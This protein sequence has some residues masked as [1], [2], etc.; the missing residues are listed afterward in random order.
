MKKSV[1][2]ALLCIIIALVIAASIFVFVKPSKKDPS[3]APETEQQQQEQ[4]KEK[5]KE[6][7]KE[8]EEE[9]KEEEQEPE[10]E[11]EPE[12]KPEPEPEPV[13]KPDTPVSNE[14]PTVDI[15]VYTM[16]TSYK[17]FALTKGMSANEAYNKLNSFLQSKYSI[18]INKQ[19][20]VESTY[21]PTDLVTLSGFSYPLESTAANALK[22]LVTDARANGITDLVLYSGYRRY[23]SQKTKY[24][25]RIQRY[26]NE[27][28]SQENA[29]KKAGEYIAPPG[30]S[31]HHTGLAA[32]VC[33]SAIVNKYGYLSDSF[34]TTKEYRWLRDN[35]ANYGFIVRYM[36]GKESITGFLYEPWHL[37]YLGVEH[38]KACTG[39]GL[40]YEEY[41]ALLTKLCNEAKADAGV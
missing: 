12:P 3:P 16:P 13:T 5:E 19:H 30:S 40:T 25:T 17:D 27:G 10:P 14:Q 15:T 35:C 4:K 21:A 7:E 2:N 20:K 23:S 34:D 39:L 37:R 24:E 31:E 8:E 28:Y 26:L 38:A 6:K 11:P 18:L 32:D 22:S 41:H 33:S 1:F 29:E 36:K 9:K